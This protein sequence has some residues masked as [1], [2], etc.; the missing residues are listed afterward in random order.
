MWRDIKEFDGKEG[1]SP[2]FDLWM[3]V[4]AAPSTFGM[5][6]AFRVVDCWFYEGKWVHIHRGA[7]AELNSKHITHFMPR[8]DGP[9]GETHY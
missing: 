6:D 7:V 9:G 3:V 2:A 5:S 1:L 4:N 8:P